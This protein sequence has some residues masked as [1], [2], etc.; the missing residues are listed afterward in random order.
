LVGSPGKSGSFFY[1][2]HDTRYMLKTLTKAEAVFLKS[3]LRHYYDVCHHH[4]SHATSRTL[5][6]SLTCLLAWLAD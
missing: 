1:Y 5:I 4:P 2:S 3:I 6:H